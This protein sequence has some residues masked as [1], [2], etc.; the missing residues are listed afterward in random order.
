MAYG[1]TR[2]H[3][4]R[5]DMLTPAGAREEDSLDAI[6]A[7]RASHA[8]AILER[9]TNYNRI[10]RYERGWGDRVTRR[11]DDLQ[12]VHRLEE[13]VHPLDLAGLVDARSR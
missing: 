6:D 8:D 7:T 9:Q 3:I 10:G 13:L 2:P 12:R 11:L 5:V 1:A 4:Q